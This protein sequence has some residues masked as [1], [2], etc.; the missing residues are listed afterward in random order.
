M[1]APASTLESAAL[2]FA[3]TFLSSVGGRRLMILAYHR[4]LPEPDPLRES[5]CAVE[6]FTWQME[7]LA[8][9]FNVLP[10]ETALRRLSERSLPARAMCITFD[11]G[12]ADNVQIALPVLQ[13]LGLSATFFI[14]TG[15]LDGGRM[16]NDSIIEA[17]RNAPSGRLDLAGAGL[18]DYTLDGIPGRRTV[19]E[20]IIK[21]IKYLPMQQRESAVDAVVARV[22]A[23]LPTNL[24]MT[25]QDIGVLADAGMA[26]GGHTVSHPILTALEPARACAEIRD[27]K[28]QLEKLLGRNLSLFAYPNGQPGR[29]Y[30]LRHAELVRECGF[31]AAVTTSWGVANIDSDRFQLPRFMPWDKTPRKFML[32]LLHN[33][34]RRRPA[35]CQDG[36]GLPIKSTPG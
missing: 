16:W 32:R 26:I 3:G 11:D 18:A 23:D 34:T 27:G 13:R 4:V 36:E 7:L 10:L 9:H 6:T 28:K 21:R 12:Y 5:I 1:F 35:L 24:M 31:S 30:D 14:A 29:D 22:G 20:D 25:S 2:R 19:I 8:G 15:F 33:Y 17:I